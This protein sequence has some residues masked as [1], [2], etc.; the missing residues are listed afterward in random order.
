MPD[1]DFSEPR[2]TQQLW[3]RQIL[4]CW[5]HSDRPAG[6]RFLGS[7]RLKEKATDELL[8]IVG[9]NLSQLSRVTYDSLYQHFDEPKQN[10][11]KIL[12]FALSEYAY[13]YSSPKDKFWQGFCQ[14]LSLPYGQGIEKTFR[15]ITAEG[16]DILG[17]VKAKSGY[18]YVSTLWLQS[19]IPKQNLAHFGQL[20]QEVSDEYGWWELAHTEREDLSQELLDFCQN[21]HPQWGTLIH[22]LKSS[23]SLDGEDE[24]EPISGH[25]VQGIATVAQELERKRHSPELLRDDNQREVLLG[26]YYLPQNFFL[27]NWDTLIRVLTPKERPGGNHRT[28]ISRRKKP[29]SL[30]LDV[31]ES[32]NIQLVLPEQRL[33]KAEWNNL[34]GSFCQI[35]E[36]SW[37]GTIP[38]SGE[39]MIPEQVIDISRVSE[40]WTWQLLNHRRTSLAEWHLEGVASDFTCLVFD[41]WTGDRIH[42]HLP[43]PSVRGTEEIICFTPREIQLAFANGIEIL[44][45]CVP[46]SIRGWLGQ[47]VRLIT[48]ESSIVFTAPNTQIHQSISWKLFDNKQ[49]QLTGLKLKGKKY[50]YLET[51]TFWYSTDDQAVSLNISI[52]SLTCQSTIINTTETLPPSNSW[53]SIS[54]TRWITEPG[55]YEARFWNQFHRWSYRF[56]IKSEY[57]LTGKPGISELKFNSCLLGRIKSL[58]IKYNC[59]EKFWSEVVNIEGLWPLELVTFSL[60]NRYDKVFY[61]GQANSS[62]HLNISLA[63]LHDL[64]PDSDWYALDYQLLGLEHQR[65]MEM[66]TAAPSISWTW[67]NQAIHLSGLPSDQLYSLSCWNL[68]LPQSQHVNLKIP[69]SLQ[70]E[71]A[72]TVPLNLPAGIYYIQLTNSRRMPQHL[73]W[74]CGSHQSDL[75]AE[76]Q[77]NEFLENYCY[78]ILGDEAVEDFLKAAKALNLDLECQWIQ[79][80]I[81]GLQDQDKGYYFPGWLKPDTLLEKLQALLQQQRSQTELTLRSQTPEFVKKP[82]TEEQSKVSVKGNWHLVTLTQA[83]K[84]GLFSKQMKIALEQNKLNDL[85]L[86]VEM[87][88]EVVY[89]NLVLLEL[90]NFK[91]V[92]DR[93]Q[94]LDCVQRIEPKPLT[95][96][97]VNQMLGLKKNVG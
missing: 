16:I 74:W 78:T 39:L 44:D 42:L 38:G 69:L 53:Q 96:E 81:Q 70:D 26:S 17:L 10:W 46:S 13:H 28:I 83:N 6:Q 22:F 93:I 5:V 52:E 87:P 50:T 15:D 41:A 29:L 56:Y 92:R 12:T 64:L 36:A 31:A 72:I 40:L 95:P 61:L 88:E 43:N 1:F 34:R 9:S 2:H 23:C 35:L 63:V 66:E 51:P 60:Y 37:E 59:L 27:R 33:W 47:H 55:A 62:G 30:V 65:L 7:V 85:I 71:E 67:A 18:K 54:L 76:T 49:P 90:S 4:P 19:G 58:P 57:Q 75:P 84:R 68:L 3:E 8:N 82:D 77:A 86:R 94:Q 79:T 89:Q 24:V 14:Q 48:K 97:Q 45:S 20:V 21:K 73:G 91:A 80:V 32:L 25:L 11:L